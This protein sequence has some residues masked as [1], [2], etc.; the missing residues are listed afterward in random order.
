MDHQSVITPWDLECMLC[1]E[2]AEPKALPLSLLK[3]ITH[4]FSD[5]QAIG[6]GGFAVV[7]KGM[8][9]NRTVAVKRMSNTYMYEKEFQREVECLMIAKHKNVVRFLGYCADTQ[10]NMARY[11]GKFV[12]ADVQQRLL[13]FEYLPKGSLH[14]YITDMSCGLQWRDRYQI[15]TGICQGLHY[16]HHKHIV[17]LDLKP[18]NILLDDDWVPKI[19]D[20]GISRCFHEMQSQVITKIAGTPG[21]L[22]PESYNHTKVT[23][24]HSYRL[25][26]YSLGIVII[27]ILTGNKG[28]HDVDKVGDVLNKLHQDAPNTPRESSS[29]EN[30]TVVTVAGTNK[31]DSFWRNMANLDMFNET[32]HS[33]DPDIKRCFEYCSIFPRGSKL[34]MVELVHLWIAQGFVKIS[35]ATEDMEEVAEGYFQELVSRSFLQPEESSYDTGCFTIHDALLDLFDKVSGDCFRIENGHRGDGWEGDI[36]QDIQHLLIRYYDGKL[37]TEKILGLENLLTLIVY[38]V[39]AAPVEERVIESICKR[40]PKLRVLAIPF[41]LERYPGMEPNELSVPGSITQLKHLRYL[42]FRTNRACMLSIP[43]APNKHHRVQVLDFGDGKLDEFNCVDLINLR[44]INSGSS[45]FPFRNISRLTSLQTIACAFRIRDAPGYEVKQL[46]DLNKLR[47][48]LEINGL[49]IVK[50]KEEALESKLAAKERLS[51]LKLQW[52]H[53]SPEVQAEVLEGLCPPVAL[54]TLELHCYNGSRYPDWM[55]GKPDGGP[56]ELQELLFW[57]CSQLEHAPEAFPHLRV[58]KLAYCNWDALPGNMEHLTSL[59]K[60]EIEWC[61]EIRSLPTLPQS[62]EEFSVEWCNDGFMKSCQIFGHPNWQKIEHIPRKTIEGLA[63]MQEVGIKIRSG[64]NLLTS[65]WH[66]K[67]V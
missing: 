49:E 21:Y 60:L 58:L 10:G 19:T 48:S 45:Q 20:F 14:E 8:L 39:D 18:A 51:E 7:Y 26:I 2:T 15:I 34:R 31:Y 13:C 9:E 56:K 33:L 5:K 23:Y 40:L 16:L 42:A 54:Q 3:K 29:E 30:A 4:D 17:H 27:E 35:C 41:I 57:S 59:K 53:S 67:K 43:R 66:R 50:S 22:A 32:I 55:V 12:M 52:R 64:I 62:L 46:R 37:I 36:R 1:D 6:R 63:P 61:S 24:R 11:E 65:F 47:G 25:D 44:H 28:Y 38:K